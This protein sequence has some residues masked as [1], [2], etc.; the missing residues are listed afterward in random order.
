MSEQI[1]FHPLNG[2]VLVKSLW[3]TD[4]IGDLEFGKKDEAQRPQKW[5]VIAFSRTYVNDYWVELKMDNKIKF[6]SIVYFTPYSSDPISINGE[7]YYA[8]KFNVLI[9][10]EN[11]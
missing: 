10:I 8:V 4:K 3:S 6:W 11:L 2:R 9:G 5:E 7:T 1:P